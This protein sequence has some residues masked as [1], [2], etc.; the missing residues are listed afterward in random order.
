MLTIDNYRTL[1]KYCE[2][3]NLQ[4][5]LQND[6]HNMFI[7]LGIKTKWALILQLSSAIVDFILQLLCFNGKIMIEN[8]SSKFIN[9]FFNCIWHDIITLNCEDLKL[10]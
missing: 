5:T 10:K 9:N 3:I 2:H 6:L 4:T 8:V 1:S 7:Y